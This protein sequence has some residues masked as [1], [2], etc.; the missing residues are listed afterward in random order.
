M[1]RANRLVKIGLIKNDKAFSPEIEGYMSFFKRFLEGEIG[2]KFA[3]FEAM[4][5]DESVSSSNFEQGDFAKYSWDKFISAV[6]CGHQE[7]NG[8]NHLLLIQVFDKAIN[9]PIISELGAI[10][11]A[12]FWS[13]TQFSMGSRTVENYSLNIKRSFR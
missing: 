3:N 5:C 11:E 4:A 10:I 13:P 7:R 1:V 8:Y 12:N 2:A 6:I 9:K